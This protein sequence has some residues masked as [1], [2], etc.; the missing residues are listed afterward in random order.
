MKMVYMFYKREVPMASLEGDVNASFFI[1]KLG[2]E[3][4]R[5]LQS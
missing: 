1:H 2:N 5:D 3:V 4:E